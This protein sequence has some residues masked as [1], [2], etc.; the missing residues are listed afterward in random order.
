MKQPPRITPHQPANIGIGRAKL[1]IVD[2]LLM[3]LLIKNLIEQSLKPFARFLSQEN[4]LWEETIS[5]E[6]YAPD[7]DGKHLPISLDRQSVLISQV[8]LNLTIEPVQ[9][10][11]VVREYRD[12]VHISDHHRNTRPFAW[13]HFFLLRRRKSLF[14]GRLAV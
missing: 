8:F 10:F 6:I 9:I 12:I 3:L 1:M 14:L 13:Q 2:H 5:N 11:L 7:L 4:I